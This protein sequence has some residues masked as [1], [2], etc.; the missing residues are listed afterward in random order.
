MSALSV[1]P[2]S[3]AYYTRMKITYFT[4]K[5]KNSHVHT[6]AHTHK[7]NKKINRISKIND[8]I[9]FPHFKHKSLEICSY[10]KSRSL[11]PC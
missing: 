9:T 4:S 8:I 5:E 11:F 7:S 3:Q 10:Y 2:S 6:C 1:K